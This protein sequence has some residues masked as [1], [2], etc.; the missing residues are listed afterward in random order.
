MTGR[1]EHLK[2]LGSELTTYK[3]EDPNKDMLETF[4]APQFEEALQVESEYL[5]S[6]S[7][8]EFTSLCPKTGQPDYARIEVQYEPNQRCI[9]TKSFK[10]YLFAFRNYRG[11]MEEITTKILSDLVEVC[12]P[13]K[14]TIIAAFNVRGGTELVCT[15]QYNQETE[16]GFPPGFWKSE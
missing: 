5:V 8:S 3:L 1:H 10:L 16:A 6:L 15:A 12:S 14:M 13:R 4:E 2:N 9:E 7:S 11:F